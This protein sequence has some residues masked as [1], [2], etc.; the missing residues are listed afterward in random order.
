MGVIS[1][2]IRQD[3]SSYVKSKEAERSKISQDI[4][5][6]LANGGRIDTV[7]TGL[8]YDKRQ[9]KTPH[10]WSGTRSKEEITKRQKA[11]KRR[12]GIKAG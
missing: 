5:T 11:G 9:E 7:P 8:G 2:S 4:D 12:L 6:F 3:H 1:E 10:W